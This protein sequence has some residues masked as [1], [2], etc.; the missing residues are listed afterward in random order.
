[1]TGINSGYM[2]LQT[3]TA[4]LPSE[5]K[6]CASLQVP[7]SI[8]PFIGQEDHVSMDLS[9]GRKSP[10]VLKKSKKSGHKLPLRRHSLLIRKPIEITEY[11]WTKYI[12][13]FAKERGLLPKRPVFFRGY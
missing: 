1:M 5:N 4:A 13:K 11:Y 10:Q 7:D 9:V 3:T 8:S 6:D 2:I 12:R